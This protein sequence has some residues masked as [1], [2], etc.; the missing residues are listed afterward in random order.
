MKPSSRRAI[1]SSLAI[2]ALTIYT[3]VNA[4]YTDPA[5]Y[6]TDLRKAKN[7]A[8]ARLEIHLKFLRDK[9]DEAVANKN[10]DMLRLG[11]KEKLNVALHDFN[12][13]RDDPKASRDDVVRIGTE[14]E[15]LRKAILESPNQVRQEILNQ[16]APKDNYS[17]KDKAELKAKIQEKWK[18]RYPKDEIVAIRFD[19]DNWERKKSRNW[20]ANGAYWQNV[21]VST[22]T[23]RVI[24]KKDAETATIYGI[25]LQRDHDNPGKGVEVGQKGTF[26]PQDILL[27]NV[28]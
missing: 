26:A 9:H 2:C 22:L 15:R 7:D 13:F 27:A 20:V 21:D 1:F 14:L 25:Y 3:P 16:P 5:K 10:E 24:V 4:Q 11:L 23:V 28:K 12:A 19:R 6:N 8:K 18:E 17:G